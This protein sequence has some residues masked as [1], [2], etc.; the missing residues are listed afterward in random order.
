MPRRRG[1]IEVVLRFFHLLFVISL[2]VLLF[3][4][5]Y[6]GF[7]LLA[8][9]SANSSYEEVVIDVAERRKPTPQEIVSCSVLSRAV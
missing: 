3:R 7:A 9:D 6:Y 2:T 1:A 4:G 8:E 5:V